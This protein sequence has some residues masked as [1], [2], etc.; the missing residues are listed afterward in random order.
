MRK[1]LAALTISAIALV[2]CGSSNKSDTGATS[3]TTRAE[4]AASF[5]VT[6]GKV[7]IPSRPTHIISLSATATEMVYAVGAGSQVTAVDKYST[8]PKRAPHTS[9]DP[10]AISAEAVSARDPDLVL[11][12][13]DTDGK[14]A[15]GLATLKIPALLLPAAKTMDDSYA[16]IR[17]I[18]KATG[19]AVG[20]TAEVTGIRRALDQVVKTIGG[21][22]KGLSYYHELDNTLYTATSKTFIGEVYARLGMVNIADAT[23]TGTG[24]YPQ[25]SAEYIVQ[26]DPDFVFLADTICCQQDAK[27]FAARPGFSGLKAVRNGHV[28]PL[29][30]D[31][32][33]HWGPRIVDFMRTVGDAIQGRTTTTG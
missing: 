9:L 11:Y 31:L 18:G 7:T 17:E 2:G 33:S 24:D 5:P 6:I 12:S 19:H 16:Q 1:L 27:T 25:L 14:L 32:A 3:S 20:A 10:F 28:V 13:D 30:D 15:A 23:P 21:R 4:A 29:S 26:K 22:A 8:F